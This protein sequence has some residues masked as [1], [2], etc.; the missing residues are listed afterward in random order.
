MGRNQ[1]A[2]ADAEPSLRLRET[3]L[4]RSIGPYVRGQVARILVQAGAY[5]RVL[6]ILE[7]LLSVENSDL[8]PAWLRLDPTFRPLRGNPRFE[9][10]TAK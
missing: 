4:D 3:S 2:I 6:E 5:D 1:D 8:T 7:P 10:M 9:R